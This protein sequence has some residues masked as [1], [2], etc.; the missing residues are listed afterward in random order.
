MMIAVKVNDDSLFLKVYV[1]TFQLR[2]IPDEEEVEGS[3]T[4]LIKHDR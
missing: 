1:S 2:K 4:Y 3:C